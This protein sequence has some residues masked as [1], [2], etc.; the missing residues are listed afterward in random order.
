M[1]LQIYTC[2]KWV[3]LERISKDHLI[4]PHYHAQGHL[5]VPQV[6]QSPI[7]KNILK[8]VHSQTYVTSSFLLKEGRKQG[9]DERK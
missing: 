1:Y 3:G 5:L 8:Y 2:I 6:T 9:R 7:Q 4:H